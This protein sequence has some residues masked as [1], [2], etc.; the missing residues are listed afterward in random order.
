MVLAIWDNQ[1]IAKS[2]ETRMVEGNHYFPAESV[3]RSLLESSRLH[4]PCYWKGIASYYH[5]RTETGVLKNAAWYYPHPPFWIR[6][7]R[8]H[9]AFGPGVQIKDQMESPGE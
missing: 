5:L 7:I 2:K 1:V 9:I 8:N 6:G 3:D 4:T